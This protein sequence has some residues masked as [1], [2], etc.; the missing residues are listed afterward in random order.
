MIYSG[1]DAFLFL[2]QV[3]TN[4]AMAEKPIRVYRAER[5]VDRAP[6]VVFLIDDDVACLTYDEV[7][8]LPEACEL[9]DTN[10]PVIRAAVEAIAELAR[11]TIGHLAGSSPHGPH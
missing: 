6:C 7:N 10:H 4:P 8:R 3:H 5:R 9:V 2:V 11:R 1:K